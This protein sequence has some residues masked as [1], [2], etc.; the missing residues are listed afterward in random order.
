M[1]ENEIIQPAKNVLVYVDGS[2]E[3]LL[4]VR[5]AVVLCRSIHAA[6][7]AMYVVNTRALEDLVS[8]H[9]LIKS[10]EAEYQRDLE[11]DAEK[12]L[13][14]AQ[15]L[16]RKKNID[17]QTVKKSG[18]ISQEI[19]NYIKISGIDLL[20]VGEL[21]RVQSRRDELYSETER[22]VRGAPCSVLIIRND[23]RI[24]EWFGEEI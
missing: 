17:V 23:E 21:P 7:T 9:I 14:F 3:S 4:A 16:G 12:Y 20:I 5:Y 22:A 19:K 10:E 13:A 24:Y 6:L 15:K 8:A 18:S 2:E 1:N 11:A